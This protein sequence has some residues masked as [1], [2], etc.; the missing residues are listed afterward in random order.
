MKTLTKLGGAAAI[1]L[2]AV[3]LT[4]MPAS[5]NS[6]S[7]SLP[8]ATYSYNDG[9]DSFCVTAGNKATISVTLTAISPAG[10]TKTV[11]DSWEDAGG[12]CVSLAT[13]YEDTYYKASI[14]STTPSGAYSTTEKFYS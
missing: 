14:H 9:G 2:T 10:P 7:G 13:A 4:A 5:A 11:S 1:A 12:H 3:A 6:F 8:G